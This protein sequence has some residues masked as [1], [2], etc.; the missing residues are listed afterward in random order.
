M[1]K[2]NFAAKFKEGLYASFTAINCIGSGVHNLIQCL[3]KVTFFY[4]RDIAKYL[5]DSFAPVHTIPTSLIS[6]SL[7][8]SPA[9]PQAMYY[10]IKIHSE[11]LMEKAPLKK[12]HCHTLLSH[13]HSPPQIHRSRLWWR[14]A[15]R[16][17]ACRWLLGLQAGHRSAL[18]LR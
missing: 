3:V 14:F 5:S 9:Y 8:L 7:S 11:L 12:A 18:Q 17:P 2:L 15:S 1:D 13:N 16:K 10:T 6:L 4:S